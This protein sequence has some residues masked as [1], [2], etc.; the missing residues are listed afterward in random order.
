[1]AALRS[2]LSGLVISAVLTAGLSVPASAA[3]GTVPVEPAAAV[4]QKPD[5][6]KKEPREAAPKKRTGANFVLAAPTD[7]P[8][9]LMAAALAPATANGAGAGSRGAASMVD[10]Q[11]TDLVKL[12]FNPT[13]GNVLLTGRLLQVKGPNL[14]VNVNWRYNSLTD[15]RPTLNAGTQEAALIA[16]P[17]AGEYT[18]VADDGGWYTF[19]P[20]GAG[21]WVQPPGLRAFLRDLG[22]NTFEVRFDD[23]VHANRYTL[24]GSTYV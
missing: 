22:G 12:S 19:K 16:G 9:P 15:T 4:P 14:G 20:N 7:A 21:G 5:K 1:M 24:S 6:P 11:L 2:L 23:P 17:G 10:H 8:A 3:S 18:Y 13:N